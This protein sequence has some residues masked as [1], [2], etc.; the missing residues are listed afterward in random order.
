MAILKIKKRLI[1]GLSM[2]E[3]LWVT[4]HGDVEGFS[5]YHSSEPLPGEDLFFEYFCG[6]GEEIITI[7]GGGK[8]LGFFPDYGDARDEPNG[9]HVYTDFSSVEMR[10]RDGLFSIKAEKG[11]LPW[12]WDLSFEWLE[13]HLDRKSEKWNKFAFLMK[14]DSK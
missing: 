14:V 13:G 6:G 2:E 12:L 5:R 3:A 1:K 10:H 4:G 8:S 7:V 11:E 9:W